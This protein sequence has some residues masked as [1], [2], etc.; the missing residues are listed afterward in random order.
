[1]VNIL[2]PW[3]T[4][5]ASFLETPRID[6]CNSNPCVNNETCT[7][8]VN[9]FTCSCTAGFMGG[10]CEQSKII[11]SDTICGKDFPYELCAQNSGDVSRIK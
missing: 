9:L 2:S 6:E 8:G 4:L 10:S 7:D 3:L 1:M 11:F 5:V